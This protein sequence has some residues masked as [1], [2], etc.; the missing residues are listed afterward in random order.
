MMQ[1]AQASL[2]HDFSGLAALR[3][4]ARQDAASAVEPVAAQFEAI[5]VQQM[6]KSMRDATPEGDLFNSSQLKNWQQMFD[7]Q[8]SVDLAD[9]GGLGLAQVLVEQLQA[10]GAVSSAAEPDATQPLLPPQGGQQAPMLPPARYNLTPSSAAGK[11]FAAGAEGIQAQP[12]LAAAGGRPAKPAPPE[13]FVRELW[14]QALP[15][16]AELGVD[17]AVLIAQAALETGWGQ[18][19]LPAAAGSSHNLFNIKAGRGWQ[20]PTTT[21]QTVEYDGAAAR[22]ERASFRVYGSTAESFADYVDLIRSAPRY[23]EALASAAEPEA[24]LRELQAAGYATDPAYAD[25]ILAILQRGTVADTVAE[26]KNSVPLPPTL[27]DRR[28]EAA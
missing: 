15:A 12:P 27:S 26:L 17:P 6:L 8:L 19:A 1:A 3:R 10:A 2:Y 22:L 7:Q 25:K 21:V 14:P 13:D 24:Y 11:T 16:A 4:D 18:R 5:F 9:H 23:Q 20:G 28:P